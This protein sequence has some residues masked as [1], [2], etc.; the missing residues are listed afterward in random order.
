MTNI[1][2]ELNNRS[3]TTHTHTE[4][5]NNLALRTTTGNS[6]LRVSTHDTSA[7]A[8]SMVYFQHGN[9]ATCRIISMLKIDH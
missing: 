6:V 9:N 8:E 3:L 5:G 7:T 2:A 4:F 1:Q